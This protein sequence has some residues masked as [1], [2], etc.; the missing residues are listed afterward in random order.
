MRAALN[1][2]AGRWT[3]MRLFE[4]FAQNRQRLRNMI[5]LRLDDRLN[6]RIDPS[7][8]LQEA[9]LEI[10]QGGALSTY[11]ADPAMP[12]FLWIRFLVIEKRQILR[13]HHLQP[14]RVPAASFMTIPA[15]VAAGIVGLAGRDIA[16]PD[17]VPHTRCTRIVRKC[18]R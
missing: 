15:S 4:L 2:I 16:R 18:R 11:A 6:G 13:R 3:R 5:Q 10:A 9:Y 17:H 7:D 12:P 14:M 1:E 8:V